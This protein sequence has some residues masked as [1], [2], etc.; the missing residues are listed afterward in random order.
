MSEVKLIQGDCITEMQKLIDEGVKVDMVLT[1]PPYGTTACKWDS[2]IP[3]ESMWEC[4]NGLTYD[5][6]PVALFGS[7]PFSSYL[8]LS[9]IQNYRYDWIWHKNYSGGFVTAKKMPMKYHENIS[10]FYR[11]LPCYNPQFQEYSTDTKNRYKNNRKVTRITQNAKSTNQIQGVKTIDGEMKLDR[12]KY[13][14]SVQFFK[15]VPTSNDGRLHPTQKPV[16]LLEYLIKTYTNK[17]DTVLDFTMGS[18]STGV[19]CM[20]TNRNFIGIE[21]D[22]KYYNIAKQR[23][24]EAKAQRRLI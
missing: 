15:A 1:D 10:I 18:G 17:S 16:A 20:E 23:I 24:N 2:I 6:T 22:E 3:F 5:N 8:R 11:K 19:A 9:N 14:E 12:G 7:E 21:L 4:L 13:P